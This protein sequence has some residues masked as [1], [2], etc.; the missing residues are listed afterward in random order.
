MIRRGIILLE[1]RQAAE[2][3]IVFPGKVITGAGLLF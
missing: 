1:I 3:S 2:K